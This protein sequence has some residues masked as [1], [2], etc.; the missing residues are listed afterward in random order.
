MYKQNEAL[1]NVEAVCCNHSLKCVTAFVLFVII[2]FEYQGC[3]N[4]PAISWVGSVRDRFI[5]IWI[6]VFKKEWWRNVSDRLEP[7]CAPKAK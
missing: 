4:F 5:S 2:L 1:F 7:I 6:T 3:R